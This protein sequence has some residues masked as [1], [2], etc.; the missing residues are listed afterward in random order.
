[1]MAAAQNKSC[2]LSAARPEP[3]R[4]CL[5]IADI[6]RRRVA[7]RVSINE[8]IAAAGIRQAETYR[9]IRKGRRARPSTLKRLL[10][11]LNAIAR[12]RKP[13]PRD[14]VAELT[15]I[16]YQK[17]FDVTA[18]R[19]QMKP[20]AAREQL[21]KRGEHSADPAW[22]KASRIRAIALYLTNTGVGVRGGDLARI[23][24][25]SPAAVSIAL[26]RIGDEAE[27]GSRFEIMLGDIE[28]EARGQ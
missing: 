26:R 25:L 6:E 11:G 19:F 2:L 21:A 17:F 10:A 20:Q 1:M 4:S 28:R 15:H 14:V 5:L 27:D 8:L 12:H 3:N 18:R 9:Q 7:A 23:T 16:T 13:V 22:I 24:K